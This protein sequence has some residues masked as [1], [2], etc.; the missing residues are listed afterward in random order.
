MTTL[1]WC[2]H[3]QEDVEPVIEDNSFDH[4]FGTERLIDCTC[5]QCGHSVPE[6]EP[7]FDEPFGDDFLPC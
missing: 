3:C 1:V 6:P 4:E 7:D 2:Q 5:P